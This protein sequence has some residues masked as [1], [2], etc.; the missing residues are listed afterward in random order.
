VSHVF[1]A[2]LPRR[3]VDDECGQNARPHP[4][5]CISLTLPLLQLNPRG[6][7]TGSLPVNRHACR[8]SDVVST[9]ALCV[10]FRSAVT[11]GFHAFRTYRG[12]RRRRCLIGAIFRAM[13]RRVPS[14]GL[15]SYRHVE[16]ISHKISVASRTPSELRV[17][18]CAP[19]RSP[20]RGHAGDGRTRPERHAQL[21]QWTVFRPF[22]SES[23][24]LLQIAQQLYPAF[25]R[26]R[27]PTR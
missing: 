16:S 3:R 10:C 11:C 17:W 1:R 23:L 20:D 13:S 8:G 6:R 9:G 26:N 12:Y 14:C 18:E 7:I 2:S 15:I 5:A 4:A 25:N 24:C 21:A 19:T 22:E 27:R